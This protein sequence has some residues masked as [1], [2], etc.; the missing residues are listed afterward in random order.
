ME[1]AD[2][3][4]VSNDEAPR[5]A[6]TLDEEDQRECGEEKAER[7]HRERRDLPQS[8]LDRDKREAPERNDGEDQREIARGKPGLCAQSSTSLRVVSDS[9]S[10]RPIRVA[11][12]AS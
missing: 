6:R 5:H 8:D 1:D 7:G 10:A 3:E 9:R 12:A 4:P 2:A 11:S